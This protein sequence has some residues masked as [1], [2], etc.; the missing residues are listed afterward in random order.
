MLLI[1]SD[2]WEEFLVERG[3][4]QKKKYQIVTG[5]GGYTI[6]ELI[7][8]AFVPLKVFKGNGIIFNVN[9]TKVLHFP[10]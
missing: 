1:S 9:I 10:L 6:M 5:L 4:F 8:P 2:D 3:H 7:S